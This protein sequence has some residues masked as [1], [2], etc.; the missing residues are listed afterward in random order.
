MPPRSPSAKS[1]SVSK[2]GIQLA[3]ATVLGVFVALAVLGV[4]V[5]GVYEAHCAGFTVWVRP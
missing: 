5:L 3:T 2:R 1:P 4:L